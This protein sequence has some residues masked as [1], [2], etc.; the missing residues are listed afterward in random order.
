V[1]IYKRIIRMMCPIMILFLIVTPSIIAR[2]LDESYLNFTRSEMRYVLEPKA[3]M[4][5]RGVNR[6]YLVREAKSVRH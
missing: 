4:W 5:Q 2:C 3:K 6:R 1:K